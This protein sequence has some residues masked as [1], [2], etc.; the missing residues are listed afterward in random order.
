MKHTYTLI[1]VKDSHGNTTHNVVEDTS[2]T[3]QL[4]GLR[5]QNNDQI[6][7]ETE[8][9]HANSLTDEGCTVK[10]IEKEFDFETEF[11]NA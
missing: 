10:M 1:L 4:C 9:Y 8:A 6:Y 3:I 7:F 5:D 11:N 2:D